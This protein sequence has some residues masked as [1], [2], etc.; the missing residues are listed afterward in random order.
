[1]AREALAGSLLACL[2]AFFTGMGI[3]ARPAA[4]EQPAIYK[5]VDEHG[6]AH[7]T[8][9]RERIPA[10][11]R[12]R[13]EQRGPASR[14]ADWLTRDAGAAPA[15]PATAGGEPAPSGAAPAPGA[16]ATAAREASGVEPP[17]QNDGVH[18]VPAE[19]DWSAAPGA[20][21]AYAPGDLGDAESARN[22]AAAK[23]DSAERPVSTV[24]AVPTS[25][26]AAASAPPLEADGAPIEAA[27][28]PSAPAPTTQPIDEA[29]DEQ[30][31]VSEAI[32]AAPVEA[33]PQAEPTTVAATPAPAPPE[34]AAAPPV[35]EPPAEPAEP[36][37]SWSASEPSEAAAAEPIVEPAAETPAE[38][39]IAE[40]AAD[41][42]PA[43]A[44]VAAPAPATDLSDLD[45]RIRALEQE[46]AQDEE[47]LMT[48][49]SET[50]PERKAPLAD[51]PAFREIAQRL[52]KKQAELD[53]LREQRGRFEPPSAR[54]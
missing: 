42:P 13:I 48:L 29:V 28:A 37:S 2:A 27:E 31:A 26:V 40:P 32:D 52:P 33:A 19:A 22:A 24:S 15:L 8:T 25:N 46:I 6:V 47:T 50:E 30:P 34:P 4:A 10:A 16:R 11:I 18:A 23:P 21:A 14:G 36:P 12:N 53:T 44:A 1:M 49:I 39:P 43:P 41:E 38:E 5:W 7:Y 17:E 54:P 51:D 20:E 9:D 35:A 45:A 3:P